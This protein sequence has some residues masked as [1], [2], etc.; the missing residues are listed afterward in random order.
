MFVE[1]DL[2]LDEEEWALVDT[3]FEIPDVPELAQDETEDLRDQMIAAEYKLAY[4]MTFVDWLMEE[5]YQP[6][7]VLRISFEQKVTDN[8]PRLTA[9]NEEIESLLASLKQLKD[10]GTAEDFDGDMFTAFTAATFD[11]VSTDIEIVASPLVCHQ[12]T[13]DARAALVDLESELEDALT[14]EAWLW[15]QTQE[16]CQDLGIEYVNIRK[17]KEDQLVT[18]YSDIASLITDIGA[19]SDRD[20]I[21]L[22]QEYVIATEAGEVDQITDP[23]VLEDT[24]EE[25]QESTHD[26][27]Q[28]AVDACAEVSDAETFKAWLELELAAECTTEID[29]LQ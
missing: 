19:I 23:T 22:D 15:T 16:C 10:D 17:D 6:C 7:E 26:A 3:G 18:L 14:Y 29:D 25:C 20:E 27:Y 4:C 28:N 9:S 12:P 13:K 24:P 8:T 11:T 5:I 21:E 1:F 2:H